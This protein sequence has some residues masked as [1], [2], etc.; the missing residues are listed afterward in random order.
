MQSGKWR[1]W[2]EPEKR[3]TM[4]L[5]GR[6]ERT[7]TGVR[8]TRDT[9]FGH[10]TQMFSGPSIS[11]EKWEELE[12]VLISADVGVSTAM[13]LVE[14]TRER[15]QEQSRSDRER[16]ALYLMKEELLALLGEASD[17][18]ATLLGNEASRPK[19][20]VVLVVGVNGSGK[21]TSIAKLARMF[22]EDGAQVTLGAGDTFRAGAI[23]QLK[24]WAKRLGVE[25]VG[26]QSGGDSAAVAYDTLQ[27]ARARGSDVAIID[28]AGRLHTNRNLMEELSKVQRVLERIDPEAPHMTLLVLDATTGQNGLAQAKAFTETITCDGVLLAKLDGTAKGGIVFSIQKELG[29]PVL[30]IGTGET[31]DDLSLFEPR[32]FV[33]ALL[34][35]AD[36]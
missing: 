36:V 7:E 27:A 4:K 19:P 11:E 14:R 8:R 20:V 3:V 23:E 30:F 9:W 21:T 22:Q 10:I 12:E 6:K 33:N 32:Q 16:S 18:T 25:V 35:P 15:V 24:T 2:A 13:A 1:H 28:T 26:N 17:K 31:A 5:F 34:C 29:L